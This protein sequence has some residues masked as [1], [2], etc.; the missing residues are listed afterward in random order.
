MLTI[1]CSVEEV[2]Q[3]QRKLINESESTRKIES[4]RHIEKERDYDVGKRLKF[5]AFAKYAMC[6]CTDTE[7]STVR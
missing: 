6:M 2:K 4:D 5:I 3:R 7:T 1:R